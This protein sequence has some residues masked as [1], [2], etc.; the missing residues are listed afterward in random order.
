MSQG[1]SWIFLYTNNNFL[2]ELLFSF[3]GLILFHKNIVSNFKKIRIV[4]ALKIVTFTLIIFFSII[5][6]IS[7]TF[8][9]TGLDIKS[10]N[11]SWVMIV[12]SILFVPFVEE[13]VNRLSLIILSEKKYVTL[14]SLIISS[15]LFMFG[16]QSVLA[17]NGYMSI[18]YFLL[19]LFL[20]GIYLKTQNIWYSIFTHSAYN[21]TAMLIM[22]IFGR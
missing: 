19:G 8:F 5:Y 1:T 11:F 21:A 2:L 3:W 6:G 13:I 7:Y 14:I 16:H 17:T 20:G 9:G 18:I 15:L 12:N 10:V 22:L 4:I